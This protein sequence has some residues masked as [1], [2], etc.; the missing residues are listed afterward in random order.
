MIYYLTMGWKEEIEKIQ[1]KIADDLKLEKDA[2]A[3]EKRRKVSKS[4]QEQLD[5]Q[6]QKNARQALR[7][8]TR[9]R[10]PY[11]KEYLAYVKEMKKLF[12]TFE[13]DTLLRQIKKYAWHNQGSIHRSD[14]KVSLEFHYLGRKTHQ[15]PPK[16]TY[17]GG[18]T[19]VRAGMLTS[20]NLRSGKIWIDDV[21]LRM[22]LNI[23][24][25]LP[26]SPE[27]ILQ[28]ADNL[29]NGGQKPLPNINVYFA[30]N[31]PGDIPDIQPHTSPLNRTPLY[32]S[33]KQ[34]GFS[35]PML[36]YNKTEIIDDFGL[37]IGKIPLLSGL[38][39]RLQ[40]SIT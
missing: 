14:E 21:D 2:R 30:A 15:D 12:K 22:S 4:Q 3:E 32:S 31:N 34:V 37:F 5:R 35:I 29:R 39:Q 23:G 8:V 13:F 17:G 40:S 19:S 26:D 24:L 6:V 1:L 38:P 25:D 33:G 20:S 36:S 9:E 27:A 28:A 18:S 7:R 16:R 10:K 11:E